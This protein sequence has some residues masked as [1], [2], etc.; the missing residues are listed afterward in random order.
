[1]ARIHLMLDMLMR[2]ELMKL[3]KE[4]KK[5]IWNELIYYYILI[6]EI[7]YLNNCIN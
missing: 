7:N 3:N 4:E 1:M 6:F 2:I 5:V